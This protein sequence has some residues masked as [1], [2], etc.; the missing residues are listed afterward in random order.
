MMFTVQMTKPF[1]EELHW[2][3][4]TQRMPG[5]LY[6]PAGRSGTMHNKY[7]TAVTTQFSGKGFELRLDNYHFSQDTT[8]I[9]SHSVPLILLLIPWQHDV[10]ITIQDLGRLSFQEQQFDMLYLMPRGIEIECGG[11]KNHQILY[12]SL[13]LDFFKRYRP[14]CSRMATMVEAIGEQK[15]VR[16]LKT[17]Q[18]L[19]LD[20]TTAISKIVNYTGRPEHAPFYFDAVIQELMTLMAIKASLVDERLAFSSYDI[21]AAQDARTIIMADFEAFHTVEQLARKVGLT[22]NKLQQVFKHLYGQT[23]TTFS[24]AARLEKGHQLLEQT[25]FPLRVICEIVGYP[26]PSN[27]SVAFRKQ[28]GYWPGKVQKRKK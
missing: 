26:D 11:G 1:A 28:Y 21:S 10:Q 17:V 2:C 19:S 15:T 8:I 25:T 18:F 6:L 13:D 14:Y 20:M 12:L 23:V 7:G 22:E 3:E 5:K 4:H 16:M 27:F 24:R 9:L